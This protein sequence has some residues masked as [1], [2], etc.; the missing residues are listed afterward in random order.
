MGQGP[1]QSNGPVQEMNVYVIHVRAYQVV[2]DKVVEWCEHEQCGALTDVGSECQTL[3]S[4]RRHPQG[5]LVQ[6]RVDPV[7]QV[8]PDKVSGIILQHST[9]M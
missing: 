9:H 1:V 8:V 7:R 3:D 4:R 6:P 5:H 2:H